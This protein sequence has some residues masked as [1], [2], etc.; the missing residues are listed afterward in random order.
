MAELGVA[1]RE[2]RERDHLPRRRDVRPLRPG[3]RRLDHAAVRVPD[4]VHALP[5]R[6]LAGH[7]PGDVRVPDRDLG[8]DRP[9][10]R[11]RGA[12]RD[13]VVG[14]LGRL[15]G[16]QRDG[17]RPVPR[18]ARACTRTRAR[19]SRPT[20]PASAREIDEVPLA[21]GATDL[22]ALEA[23][24]DDERRGGVPPAAELPRHGRGP[25][26]A[27]AGGEA[28]GR[29]AGDDGGRAHARHPAPAG[30]VR[31]GRRARRGPA[32][33]QPARLRRARRSASS[34]R[35]RSTSAACRGASPARRPTST[36]A[37]AS[38]SPCRR[39]SSTS[40]ARRRRRTSAPASS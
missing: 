29:A 6:D 31:R 13:A 32:A 10:G 33:R 18:L 19:R 24:V 1:Q 38:C 15:S 11:Q 23:A 17:P 34:R 39:A 35:A 4:P 30:R 26:G 36:A 22:A 16:A 25:G 20:R 21:D 2:R 3:D 5:A 28:R 14:R 8:A 37:A 40:A 9:A 7:S 12:V 27:R